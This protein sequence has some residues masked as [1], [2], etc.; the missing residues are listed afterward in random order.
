MEEEAGGRYL[1]VF[2]ALPSS[3]R[4]READDESED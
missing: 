4:N 3:E 2:K 1:P